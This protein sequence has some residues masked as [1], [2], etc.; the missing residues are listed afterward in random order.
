M[1][2]EEYEELD[3]IAI[4]IYLDYGLKRFPI[5]VMSLCKKMNIELEKYSS[6][7]PEDR[8]LLYK[9]SDDGFY[10]PVGRTHKFSYLT[11]EYVAVDS[12]GTIVT[13]FIPITSDN[14]W[15]NLKNRKGVK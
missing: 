8:P 9:K 12:D 14:Y 13:Y 4:S 1:A 6:Y 15:R 3:K 10:F 7:K 2:N 11:H 5:R